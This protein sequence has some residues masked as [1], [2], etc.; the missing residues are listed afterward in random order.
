MLSHALSGQDDLIKREL[1]DEL[2]KTGKDMDAV[3][4][5][6]TSPGSEALI[7]TESFLDL[8]QSYVEALCDQMS[9]QL[10]RLKVL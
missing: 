2:E 4:E 8:I 1:V 5:Y 7:K 3:D 6:N 9:E 10:Q